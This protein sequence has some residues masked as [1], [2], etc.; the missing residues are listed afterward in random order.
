MDQSSWAMA[1]IVAFWVI[2]ALWAVGVLLLIL[3]GL[4]RRRR[5]QRPTGSWVAAGAVLLVGVLG[6]FPAYFIAVWSGYSISMDEREARAQSPEGKRELELQ[7]QREALLGPGTRAGEG[8]AT[9]PAKVYADLEEVRAAAPGEWVE[10]EQAGLRLVDVSV[11]PLS[12]AAAGEAIDPSGYSTVTFTLEVREA[13]ALTGERLAAAR[14]SVLTEDGEVYAGTRCTAE[15][16]DASADPGATG[17]GAASGA[18]RSWCRVVPTR[19]AR[20]ASLW[21][22]IWGPE[23]HYPR[24]QRF[25][26]G[27]QA[28]HQLAEALAAAASASSSAS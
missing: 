11:A 16:P 26:F 20:N 12:A 8:P 19:L 21:L 22:T 15:A 23:Q 24:A 10:G 13:S 14:A 17:S 28:S 7:E 9:L 1:P 5:G 3:R 27:P 18:A 25:L 6:A 4:R 2:A